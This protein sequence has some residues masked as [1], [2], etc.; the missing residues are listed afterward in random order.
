[1]STNEDLPM[2][3]PPSD[4]STQTELTPQKEAPVTAPEPRRNPTTQI[5][6]PV[7][8]S[9]APT[10][11]IPPGSDPRK[12]SEARKPGTVQPV[13]SPSNASASRP[14]APAV[15]APVPAA[16]GEDDDA[17]KL[18]REYAERQKTKVVRLEQQVLE[19]KKVV[20]ERDSLK[21]KV[22]SLS[23]ELQ[24]AKRQLEASAKAEEMIR[25]LQGKV[26][27]AI[28]SNS[29]LTDDK[30]KLKSGLSQQ[31][32]HLKKSEERAEQAE[33]GLAEVQEKLVE[34]T[35]AR[36]EAEAKVAAAL[37]AL[38]SDAKPVAKAPPPPPAP[39]TKL[40][41]AATRPMKAAMPEEKPANEK[42][43]SNPPKEE[44]PAAPQAKPQ[45]P[46]QQRPPGRFSFLKK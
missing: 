16:G 12:A 19:Y 29:I 14:A 10:V 5:P 1:M 35:Q 41:E 13:A 38:Q 25:D 31:T 24:D 30:N 33:K 40:S 26:D 45:N 7:G 9:E 34:E 21:A 27:A 22:D 20:A 44:K 15:K 46:P 8:R 32:E 39:A 23:K 11:N 6:K 42:A 3:S 36:E 2:I 37:T 43:A 4:D 17:E 28:L 18:L